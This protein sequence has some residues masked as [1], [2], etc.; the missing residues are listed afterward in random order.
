M[1]GSAHS[2]LGVRLLTADSDGD[3]NLT[4]GVALGD[5]FDLHGTRS[6]APAAP[7]AIIS[8][9]DC[10]CPHSRTPWSAVT[11]EMGAA[12]ACSKETFAGL[13][14][15]RCCGVAAYSANEPRSQVP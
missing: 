13:A 6:H 4:R 15:S 1:A 11:P 7:M 3:D 9:P 2:S 5:A 12:A 10:H 14:A 8:C